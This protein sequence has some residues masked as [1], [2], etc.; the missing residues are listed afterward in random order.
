MQM[1][2]KSDLKRIASSN[3]ER[4]FRPEAIAVIGASAHPEKVG[5]KVVYNLV[6]NGFPNRVYPIN[7]HAEEILGY[8]CYRSVLQVPEEIDLGII[9]VP[10]A[11]V[12]QVAEECGRKGVKFLIILASGFAEVGRIKE[13]QELVEIAQ[14]YGA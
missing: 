5:H 9:A 1:E 6:E 11:V 13:E 14:R 4:L 3:L 10:A 8:K 12:P 2:A 7:P